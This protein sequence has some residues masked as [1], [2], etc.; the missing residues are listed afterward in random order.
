[1]K[2]SSIFIHPAC[3]DTQVGTNTLFPCLQAVAHLWQGKS[4]QWNQLQQILV[5]ISG[6]FSLI[7]MASGPNF[8][9]EQ[10]KSSKICFATN[11]FLCIMVL[12]HS[13]QEPG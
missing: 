8:S 10:K 13:R 1:M 5:D 4:A 7:G 9:S 2:N 6:S 12:S 11:Q 3:E